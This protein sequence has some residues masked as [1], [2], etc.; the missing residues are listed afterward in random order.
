MNIIKRFGVTENDLRKVV[1]EAMSRGGS[2]CD[3]YFEDTLIN[4]LSLRDGAVNSASSD[5]DFGMGVRV[6][7]GDRTGYAYT[8]NITLADML[9]AA[10]TAANIANSNSAAFTPIKINEQRFK[11]YYPVG[12]FWEDVPV[13]DKVPYLQKLNNRIFELDS[14]VSKVNASLSDMSSYILF[15][16]SEGLLCADYRPLVSLSAFC[17]MEKNGRI[18]NG[19]SAHSLRK[20]VEF[21]TDELTET[22]AAKVVRLTSLMFEAITPKGGEMPVVMAAG[23]SGILLHEAIGHSFE[24]DFNRKEVSI[25]SNK[26]GEQICDKGINIVDDGTIPENRGTINF[27]D[28][29]IESQKTYLVREGRLSSYL[30]DRISAEYY[31]VAPTGNGRRES[32][33]HAPLPRMRATYMENGNIPENDIIASVKNGLYVNHFNNGEVHIGAG[34]FTFFVKSGYMIENGKL[35]QP[36]KDINIIGNGPKALADIAM[37]GDNL[38]IDNSTW[39]CGKDG[40]GVAVSQGL[41]S[42]LVKKLIVGG[43]V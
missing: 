19:Y 33:R 43:A 31:N 5:I 2:Y 8:E 36:V 18:E 40:Q 10:N 35:T 20:G 27:D 12:K 23:S 34:D 14:R 37:V 3:L 15:F 25:F 6:L 9:N 7:S 39:V 24:A 11:N 22:I 17:V 16:N 30:H 4:N 1:A 32:F 28:E 21:L 13:N 29:G 26:F 42:V 41:P 38:K